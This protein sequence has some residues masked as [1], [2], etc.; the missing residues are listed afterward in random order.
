MFAL[1]A[2]AWIVAFAALGSPAQ[3]QSYRF[4]SVEVQGNQ[5]VDPSTILTYAGISRGEAVSAAGLNDAYQRIAGSGLFESVE[6]IP[7]GSRLLILVEEF[8]TINVIS[9]EG[10]RRLSD[11]DLQSVIQSRSR[12]VYSPAQ[13]EADA[14]LIAE[15]YRVQGRLAATVQP[16]II[17]RSKAAIPL[18]RRAPKVTTAVFNTPILRSNSPSWGRRWSRTRTPS[19]FS[20]PKIRSG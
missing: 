15:G 14:A 16:K 12:R 5:R 10:N 2:T 7:Q 13:A 1:L 4:S 18:R 19:K 20:I 6:L 8:P 9:F 3:A 17:R 11:E